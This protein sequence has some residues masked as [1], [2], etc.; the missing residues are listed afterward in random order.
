MDASKMLRYAALRWR[1]EEGRLLGL[2]TGDWS[3][4]IGGFFLAGLLALMV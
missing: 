1:A 2:D 3:M 4:L